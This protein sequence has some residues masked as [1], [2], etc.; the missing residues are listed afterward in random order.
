MAAEKKIKPNDMTEIEWTEDGAKGGFKKAGAKEMVHSN[1]AEKLI[2]SGKAKLPGKAKV[3]KEE[4][5]A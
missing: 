3:V 5:K 2:A 4:V 1:L